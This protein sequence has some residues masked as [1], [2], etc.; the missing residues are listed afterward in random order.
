L[1]RLYFCFN[2]CFVFCSICL[3]PILFVLEIDTL[4]FFM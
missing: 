2:F 1:E 4:R 3:D